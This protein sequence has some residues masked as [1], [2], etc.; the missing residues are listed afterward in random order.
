MTPL[1]TPVMSVPVQAQTIHNFDFG[2]DSNVLRE[3]CPVVVYYH[4]GGGSDDDYS[5]TA[6]VKGFVFD[7]TKEY[8]LPLA[9]QTF[10]NPLIDVTTGFF[11]C[12]QQGSNPYMPYVDVTEKFPEFLGA[13]RYEFTL[14]DDNPSTEDIVFV[15][16]LTD[17]NWADGSGGS[18]GF[19]NVLINPDF[20]NGRVRVYISVDSPISTSMIDCGYYD[21]DP[22]GDDP[23]T[24]WDLVRFHGIYYQYARNRT[25]FSIDPSYGQNTDEIPYGI[26]EATLDVDVSVREDIVIPSGKTLVVTT[27]ADV[28]NS[29]L[30]EQTEVMFEGG[31]GLTVESGGTLI[32]EHYGPY[33]VIDWFCYSTP[34]KGGWKGIVGESGSTVRMENS[35]IIAADV[36]LTLQESNSGLHVVLIEDSRYRGLHI[37]DSDP[38]VNISSITG[39][40]DY[41]GVDRGVNVLIEGSNARPKFIWTG[42][43]RAI[44]SE[45]SGVYYGGHR[46]EITGSDSTWFYDCV[47]AEN[48][49][50]GF[51]IHNT[52]GP[53]IEKCRINDNG[54]NLS[55][56]G[57][58]VG[59][60][61]LVK[62]GSY[63]TTLRYSRIYGNN[64][65]GIYLHG[66]RD[67]LARIRGWYT[68][69][70]GIDP[71]DPTHVNNITEHRGYNC[72]Y[73]NTQNVFAKQYGRFDFGSEYY[74]SGGLP[75]VLGDWNSIVDPFMAQGRVDTRS[76]GGFQQNWWNNDY[77]LFAYNNSTLDMSNEL[78]GDSVGCTE[79]GKRASDPSGSLAKDILSYRRTRGLLPVP[80]ART[81]S[82]TVSTAQPTTMLLGAPYPNPFN[83][84]TSIALTLFEAQEIQLA[85]TDV[86]GRDIAILANGRYDEGRYTVSFQAGSLPSGMY[87]VVLRGAS[88]VQSHRLLLSK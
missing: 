65:Y 29:P 6:T 8:S 69:D 72:I 59:A 36:G 58:Q 22:D 15:L 37:I 60:G 26:T 71:T 9:S 16:D 64:G 45:Q 28:I 40:G 83:P 39:S 74:D 77:T 2:S 63:W 85:I 50:C 12:K 86:L 67:N 5:V 54:K 66:T 32:A 51:Y 76:H 34:A 55:G 56:V 4:P 7:H 35:L 73:A 27:D 14:A 80:D 18:A 10:S 52:I 78:A 21:S 30:V 41:H 70:M 87:H 61:I 19:R 81:E 49:S 1:M 23:I 62:E 84:Q 88:G 43:S 20:P 44:K 75:V 33:G 13:G 57:G 53:Y 17:A 3:Y 24:Y 42:V 68:H 46:V 25:G 47:I 31:T 82:G 79:L 11:H 48:D 38:F